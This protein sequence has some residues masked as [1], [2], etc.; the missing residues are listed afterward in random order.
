MYIRLT[1]PGPSQTPEITCATKKE[2]LPLLV[3]SLRGDTVELGVFE[4]L[5]LDLVE[6]VNLLERIVELVQS[7]ILLAGDLL[8]LLVELME[9]LRW[10]RGG[11]RGKYE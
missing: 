9:G 5:Q 10:G 7:Q 8:L 1:L 3:L 4:F 11:G 2:S 6:L